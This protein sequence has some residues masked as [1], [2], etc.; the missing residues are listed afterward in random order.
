MRDPD[1]VSLQLDHNEERDLLGLCLDN[2]SDYDE[3]A[4]NITSP[5]SR[6]LRTVNEKSGQK[7]DKCCHYFPSQTGLHTTD[8][9]LSCSLSS[10][11]CVA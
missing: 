3:H 1:E 7:Y 8:W 6:H 2:D 10:V 5:N 4:S 11:L 9:L